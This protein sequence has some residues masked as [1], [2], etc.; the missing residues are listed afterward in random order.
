MADPTPSAESLSKSRGWLIAGGILS[1]IVGFMAMSLPQI[2]SQVIV[3][4]LGAFSLVSG[5]I[6]LGLAIF[7]K[8]V[9]HRVL[10]A[11]SGII[12]IAAGLALLAYVTAGVAVIVLILSV[13]LIIEGIVF[14][15]GGIKMH[16]HRGGGWMILN[17][18]A[19]LALGG[20]VYY[21]WPSDT[22]WVLGLLYGINSIFGGASLLAL[23]LSAPKPTA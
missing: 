22:G 2:F 9:A 4:L 13:F 16:G 8:H 6:S 10:S 20:M 3:Q 17:G 19:A 5:V 18:V 1:L 7:G 12:R 11:L 21:H 14:I 15:S 23:G